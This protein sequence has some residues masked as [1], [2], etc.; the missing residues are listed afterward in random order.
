MAPFLDVSS[1]QR[2]D[3]SLPCGCA[4]RPL[5]SNHLPVGQS[6]PIDAPMAMGLGRATRRDNL[7]TLP[8][9]PKEGHN[10]TSPG[11]KRDVENK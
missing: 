1:A 5:Q 9:A 11:A 7:F 10:T 6:S 8:A 2:L 3:Q 4:R